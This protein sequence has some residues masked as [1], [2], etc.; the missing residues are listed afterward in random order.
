MSTEPK[1]NFIFKSECFQDCSNGS[2][3]KNLTANAGDMGLTL[4]PGRSH[5]LKS[6]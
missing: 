1:A 3:V 5:I 6:S 2:V 4:C